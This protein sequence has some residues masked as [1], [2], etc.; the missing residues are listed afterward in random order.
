MPGGFLGEGVVVVGRAVV[1]VGGGLPAWR[2]GA[3]FLWSR[4]P[5]RRRMKNIILRRRSKSR[6]CVVVV[7]GMI[8]V[9]FKLA[10]DVI[11]VVEDFSGSIGV[12][13]RDG[14][15][16]VARRLVGD[17]IPPVGGAVTGVL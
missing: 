6:C 4:R 17:L 3:M 5:R 9:L 8:V 12:G 13:V 7:V 1:V 10:G 2:Q 15:G 16:R 11:G 14:R